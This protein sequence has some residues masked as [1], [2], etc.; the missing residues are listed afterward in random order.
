MQGQYNHFM[1][2]NPARNGGFD[3]KTMRNTKGQFIKGQVPWNK[4]KNTGLVPKTAFKEN[5]KPWHK[6]MKI[7]R[8]KHPHYGH[9]QKHSKA[10]RERMSEKR[11]GRIP[12]NK[13]LKGF[14]AGKTNG[15]WRGGITP[16]NIK[17]RMSI[18]YYL[19]H[20]AV[21]ARDNWTCQKYG[22]RGGRL[23]AHHIQ[24]FAQ[25]PE[26]RFAIDNG[27]T[28]S[29]KAHKEFHDRYGRKNNTKEQ[30]MEFLSKKVEKLYLF[31]TINK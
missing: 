11:K 1:P 21:F 2:P 20:E 6:G 18:E 15:R 13:G 29:D 5:H 22:I 12:W 28:L 24:N 27:I 10:S 31:N 14:Q 25:Y 17:I 30:L 9:F 26:L 19:W 7:D 16:Q 3:Y 23:H 4:G 8:Q